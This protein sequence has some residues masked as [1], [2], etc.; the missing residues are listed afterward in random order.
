MNARQLIVLAALAGLSVVATAAVMRTNATTVASDH[1][2]EPVIPALR[3]RAKDITGLTVRDGSNT[4]TI[5]RRGN[6]FVAHFC[7]QCTP[8]H[9]AQVVGIGRLSPAHEARL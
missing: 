7:T 2:G 3:S 1:R 6:E 4:M 5:E 9:E 8:L